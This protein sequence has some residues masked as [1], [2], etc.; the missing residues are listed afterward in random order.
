MTFQSL[1]FARFNVE[2]VNSDSYH[3]FFT[4]ELS[5]GQLQMPCFSP[6]SLGGAQGM[7]HYSVAM[8]KI[9]N[10][11]TES[12]ILWIQLKKSFLCSILV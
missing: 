5:M 1:S 8:K 10:C 6:D 9:G 12:K 2:N 11:E 3:W 7:I 4:A